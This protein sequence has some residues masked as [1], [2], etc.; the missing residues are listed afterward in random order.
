[1]KSPSVIIPFAIIIGG[2]IVALAVYLTVHQAEP[3]TAAASG[4]P[5]LVRPVGPSDH[6]FGNPA[7]PVVL[8]EYADY[9]CEFCAQF[10]TTMHQIMTAEGTSGDFA[11]VFRNYPLT[12]LHPTAFQAA[13]AAECVAQASGNDAYWKFADSLFAGQPVDPLNYLS[14]AK[15]AGADVDT[16]STCL[17]NASTTVDVLI[18]ADATNAE[19]I[20][21]VGTPFSLLLIRGQ[22]PVVING[23]WPYDELKTAID[24]AISETQANGAT[25][26]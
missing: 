3:S 23:A 18:R 22:A 21:A 17:Q 10:D 4:N 19:A 20:G 15:A 1:M 2:G 13:E 9:D 24:A 16:T 14:L 5:A 11:W 26:Q 8:V 7:A 25:P 12:Q 6:A